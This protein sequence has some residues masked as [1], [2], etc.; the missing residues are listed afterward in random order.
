MN[1]NFKLG[2]AKLIKKRAL[3]DKGFYSILLVIFIFGSLF[4]SLIT[5]HNSSFVVCV[6]N[7]RVEVFIAIGAGIVT[8]LFSAGY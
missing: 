3:N 5:R 7:H 4:G 6:Q 2:K 8:G 1:C